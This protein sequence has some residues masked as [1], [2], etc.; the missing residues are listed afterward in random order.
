[1]RATNPIRHIWILILGIF[2]WILIT[3][4]PCMPRTSRWPGTPTRKAISKGT[5]STIREV[6]GPPYYFFGY[7]GTADFL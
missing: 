6:G 3:I 4:T 2:A 5:E 7:V 1:M